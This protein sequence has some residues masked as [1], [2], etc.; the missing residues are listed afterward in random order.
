MYHNIPEM[1]HNMPDNCF[2]LINLKIA[3]LPRSS[4]N[5]LTLMFN[6]KKTLGPL[7]R[8]LSFS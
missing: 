6:E 1:Y 7:L 5:G 4:M 3:T 8:L 2:L